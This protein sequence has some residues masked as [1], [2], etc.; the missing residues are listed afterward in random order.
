MIHARV[1]M[2]AFAHVLYPPALVSK[3]IRFGASLNAERWACLVWYSGEGRAQF[4]E[5]LNG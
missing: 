5:Y 3:L 2:L 4:R 1:T